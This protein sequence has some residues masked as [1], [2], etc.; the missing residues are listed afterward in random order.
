MQLR[1]GRVLLD[2]TLYEVIDFKMEYEFSNFLTPAAPT[3]QAPVA[4]SP[5]FTDFWMGWKKLPLIGNVRVGNQKEPLGMEH[6]MS[7][8][9]TSFLERSFLQDI[10]FGPFN[11][12]FNPG[13]LAFN[14]SDDERLTWAIG[15]YG[16]NS[17]PWAYSIGDDWA[18]SARTTYLLHYDEPSQG[19]YLWE[20]GVAGSVRK[21]DEDLVRLRARGN[22]RSGPPGALNPIFADTFNMEAEQQEILALESAWQWGA[23]SMEAEYVGTWAEN[24]VQPIDPPAARVDRGSPFFQ[25]GYLSLMYF[26]TGEHRTYNKQLAAFDRVIPHENFFWVDSAEGRCYGTGAWQ[27]GVR[28]SAL[29]LNDN[30]INGGILHAGT[31]GVNWYLNPNARVQFNYDLTHRSQVRD[32][33][34]GFVNGLGTR[35][36]IDF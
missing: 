6:M 25:G 19:R 32:V 12:G 24:A 8:K 31:F 13:I 34:P 22:I 15:A 21:P 14:T 26:L 27:I 35:F 33:E 1:R 17:D 5:G 4:N 2:G 7:F 30:G 10:V 9:F 29:D 28:Y 18:L 3:V 23:L 11:N 16:N 20:I 36:A